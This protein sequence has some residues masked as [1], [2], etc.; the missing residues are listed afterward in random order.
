MNDPTS[1]SSRYFIKFADILQEPEQLFS[2][3]FNLKDLSLPNNE[4]V[5]LIWLVLCL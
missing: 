2:N 4:K 1:V 3:G 5:Q